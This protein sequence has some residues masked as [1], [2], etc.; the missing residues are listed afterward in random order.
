MSALRIF[1]PCILVA[2]LGCADESRAAQPVVVQPITAQQ[3]KQFG[4]KFCFS[5]HGAEKQK[6]DF[7]FRPYA[8]K[9]FTPGERKAW[10]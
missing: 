4:E 1:I 8:E 5:C 2:A 6:G 10:E 3:L 7:D 9:G